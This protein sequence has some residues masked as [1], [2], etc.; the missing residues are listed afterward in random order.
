MAV[1]TISSK[2]PLS[3]GPS[4]SP[5][6]RIT[7][8]CII[9]ILTV[10]AITI[11]AG[12]GSY[13]IICSHTQYSVVKCDVSDTS[14]S[15]VFRCHTNEGFYICTKPLES[16]YHCPKPVF[17][18][19]WE[20]CTYIAGPVTEPF[21]DDPFNIKNTTARCTYEETTCHETKSLVDMRCCQFANV[22]RTD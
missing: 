10:L 13:N 15:Q 20:E 2:K 7:V 6:T 18:S 3:C 5:K 12:I 8:F 4:L 19:S 1:D 9:G 14:T 16:D 11:F 17:Q 22:Y 21:H